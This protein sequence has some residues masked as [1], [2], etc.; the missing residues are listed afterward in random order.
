MKRRK[1]TLGSRIKKLWGGD[2]GQAL[3]E[4]AATMSVMM[5]LLL[6]T[7]EMG[8]LAY[9]AIEVA[10]A[11]RAG[12]AYG[13]QNRTTSADTTGIQNA[14]NADVGSLTGM[15]TTASTAGI[16]A[17]GASCTGTGGTCTNTDCG[18]AGDHIESFLT[19]TTSAT[20]GSP[21]HLPGIPS[22]ITVHG[23]AVQQVTQ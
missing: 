13:A 2:D 23:N 5:A 21:I 7:V 14:A 4:T 3:I 11:A 17:S 10:N 15:V 16:C 19:V 20:I 12:V 22:S 1:F 6:G 18:T 9:A 8:R